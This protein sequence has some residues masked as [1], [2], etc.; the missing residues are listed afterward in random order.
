MRLT[1]ADAFWGRK[2]GNSQL[3]L[4]SIVYTQVLLLETQG[5]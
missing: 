3:R 5:P 1:P 4:L 2:G